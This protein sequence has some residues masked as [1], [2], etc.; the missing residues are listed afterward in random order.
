MNKLDYGTITLDILS[1]KQYERQAVY[2]GNQYVYSTVTLGITAIYNQAANS[3][4]AGGAGI[5]KFAA[6]PP[7]TDE[8]LRHRLMQPR[9]LLKLTMG[10]TVT[11]TSPLGGRSVDCTNGPRPIH[12]DVTEIQGTKTWF[13]RYVVQTDINE[14][15]LTHNKQHGT[16]SP[17]L[18]HQWSMSESID[19]HF[20]STR[21][22]TG[23]AVFDRGMLESLGTYPSSYR[24]W[25]FHPIDVGENFK[26]D[27]IRVNAV[28]PGNIVE[29]SFVDR[30]EWVSIFFGNVTKA[31]VV[32]TLGDNNGGLGKFL[33]GTAADLANLGIDSAEA[34]KAGKS[35]PSIYRYGTAPIVN[36]GRSM[37]KSSAN[38]K[39]TLYGNPRCTR[40]ELIRGANKITEFLLD[41]IDF[42]SR[43]VERIAAADYF[44]NW[45]A[46]ELNLTAG[47]IA[48]FGRKDAF[49]KFP[50][51]MDIEGFS[52]EGPK[53][54]LGN[55]VP[56]RDGATSTSLAEI[57]TADLEN[58]G[59]APT[60]P[61]TVPRKVDAEP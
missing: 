52:S 8:A 33:M 14:Y 61:T 1:V 6:P 56:P 24:K 13:V 30:Q 12:C 35:G 9:K 45:F 47:P 2:V 29:Y 5:Q 15:S 59:P 37:S 19:E 57:I 34:G 17:L 58:T 51:R 7:K 48:S 25:L 50:T 55:Q 27:K 18:S 42:T 49:N 26:R 41:R 21:E 54:F 16:P 3:Y 44:G 22:V 11:L 38:I 43:S 32:V 36:L 4:T 46:F 60:E 23:R 31:S 53:R 39:A 40:A 20:F 10:G 28:E